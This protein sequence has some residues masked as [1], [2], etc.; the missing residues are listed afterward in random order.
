MELTLKYYH[1]FNDSEKELGGNLNTPGS[2]DVL[3]TKEGVQGAYYIPEDRGAWQKICLSNES[4]KLK[5]RDIVRLIGSKFNAIYSFGVGAA[6][7]EF[8]IKKEDSS[9]QLKC[10]DFAS[11][12]V[13]RL[14]KVFVEADEV[15]SFDM[16]DGDWSVIDSQ[17][18][19]FFYRVDTV[20]DD[21]QW[22][23]VF[24]KMRS[25]GI[26]DIL[27]IPCGM[28]SLR[29]I[30]YQQVKYAVFKLLGRKMTFS[31]YI[32]TKKRFV[33]LLSEFYEIGDVVNIGG[34]AGF[35]LKLRTENNE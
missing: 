3:R 25:A 7:L 19:C 21:D 10:S 28:I 17:G 6:Y 1:Y 4:L 29:R 20:F 5:A 18:I 34:S 8:L 13:R 24:G 31:G 35:L 32:R 15:F 14:K 23:T 22:K 9:L 27:F 2:W 26:K 12:G 30:L 33:S 16:I 11:E